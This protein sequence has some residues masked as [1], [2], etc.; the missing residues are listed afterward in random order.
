MSNA[1]PKSCRTISYQDIEDIERQARY[2]KRKTLIMDLVNIPIVILGSQIGPS[3]F[4]RVDEA[5]NIVRDEKGNPIHDEYAIV[6]CKKVG[7]ED[8]L[9]FST[10]SKPIIRQLKTAQNHFM[11]NK[12]PKEYQGFTGIIKREGRR[13]KIFT[14]K[15]AMLKPVLEHSDAFA[16]LEESGSPIKPEDCKYGSTIDEETR[17][18]MEKEDNEMTLLVGD[19]LDPANDTTSEVYRRKRRKHKDI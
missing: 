12:V 10:A 16:T 14:S 3:K 7:E 4:P 8:I 19:P 11:V 13:L 15:N 18:H 17:A 9:S 1:R 5:G 2:E 6:R